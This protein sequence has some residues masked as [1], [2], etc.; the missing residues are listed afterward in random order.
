[1]ERRMVLKILGISAITPQL[2]SLAMA[3]KCHQQLV[4]LAQLTAQAPDYRL[5]FFTPDEDE[6]VDQ[7]AELIIPADDHSPGARAAKVSLF[8]DL[9]LATG[10]EQARQQWRNGLRL[11]RQEAMQTSIPAALAKAAANEAD[12]KTEIDHFFARLKEMTVLGY[13]TSSIG[14]HQDLD[15]RGNSYLTSFPGCTHPEHQ[16]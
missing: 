5:Q 13:Y 1:M 11:I 9:L 16:R 14:I 4:E 2:H 6:L 15:Y 10:D 12:P 3:A 7:L 8:A